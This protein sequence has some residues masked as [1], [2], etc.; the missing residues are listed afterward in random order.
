[1]TRERIIDGWWRS[2]DLGYI[3]RGGHT[4]GQLY[5]VDR[6]SDMIVCGGYNIYPREVEDWLHQHP[7]VSQAVVIGIPDP[8]KGEV[9]KAFVVLKPG[10]AATPEE[11]IAHCKDNLAA[12]K[13]PR[14]VAIVTLDDLPKT[15][16]GKI[17][18]RE[19]RAIE[20]QKLGPGQT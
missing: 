1:M 15:A 9:P 4:D 12:Y 10:E 3:A 8:V 11:I 16:S 6:K 13:A 5:V 17:L 7:K 18:K 20:R 2:G 14:S 19:L